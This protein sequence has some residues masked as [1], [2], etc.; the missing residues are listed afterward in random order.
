MKLN[1]EVYLYDEL[2]QY[3]LDHKVMFLDTEES[4]GTRTRSESSFDQDILICIIANYIGNL[5][6]QNKQCIRNLIYEKKYI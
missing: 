1:S 6:K 5:N 2:R 3:I 4:R